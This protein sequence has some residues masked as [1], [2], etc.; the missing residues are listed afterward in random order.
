MTP[1][2]IKTKKI[3]TTI[4][5]RIGSFKKTKLKIDAKIG[6]VAKMKTTFATLVLVTANTKAGAV[7]PIRKV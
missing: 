2:P 7:E 1:K 4:F 6:I 3:V 5:L